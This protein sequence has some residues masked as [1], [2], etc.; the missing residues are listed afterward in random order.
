MGFLDGLLGNATEIDSTE[1]SEEFD[2]I[3]IEGEQV[4]RAYK[5]IRDLIVFTGKRLIF[6]DKQGMTGKKAEYQSVPYKS[7]VRF[8][9]ESQGHFDLDAELKIW[10]SSRAEPIVKTFRAG[11][12]TTSTSS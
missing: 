8:S 10:V 5:L 12:S 4:K 6:V 2:P 11:A 9:K 3:L 1:L 7:I